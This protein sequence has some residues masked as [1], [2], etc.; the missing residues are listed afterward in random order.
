[1]ST[2]ALNDLKVTG[3][4]SLTH[5]EMFAVEGGLFRRIAQTV[6]GV[7]IVALGVTMVVKSGVLAVGSAGAL[8]APAVALAGVGVTAIIG[9]ATLAFSAWG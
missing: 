5:D 9:G 8:T 2:L 6:V 7:G 1:M 3:F 4:E